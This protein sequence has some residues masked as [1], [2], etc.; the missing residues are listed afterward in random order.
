M[1]NKIKDFVFELKSEDDSYRIIEPEEL[2]EE[3]DEYRV[4]GE[5]YK[6]SLKGQ[7]GPSS[8]RYRRK[9]NKSN[10]IG[11]FQEGI[12][13]ERGNGKSSNKLKIKGSQRI[14]TKDYNFEK[15]KR[16][17]R[18]LLNMRINHFPD[19]DMMENFMI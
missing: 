10:N 3:G 19:A 7:T 4:K 11:N 16:K 17:S 6:T 2:I 14:K 12:N 9:I 13:N 1:K 8:Y 18:S 15:N 5:W